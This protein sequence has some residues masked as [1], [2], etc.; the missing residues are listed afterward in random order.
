LLTE[1][2]DDENSQNASGP[3]LDQNES[4]SQSPREPSADEDEQEEL[5]KSKTAKAGL[6]IKLSLKPLRK[7]SRERKV[8]VSHLSCLS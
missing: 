4:G 3:I 1:C 6:R 8:R 7:S 5:N 2:E